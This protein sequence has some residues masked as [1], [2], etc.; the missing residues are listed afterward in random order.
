[1]WAGWGGGGCRCT[2]VKR[3]GGGVRGQGRLG[4]FHVKVSVV[5]ATLGIHNETLLSC[6]V[7]L[8]FATPQPS[9]AFVAG[10]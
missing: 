3:W 2:F 10:L 8:F 9:Q 4:V 6:A 7:L 1:M 5:L